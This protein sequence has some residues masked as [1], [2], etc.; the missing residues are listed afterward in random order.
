MPTPKEYCPSNSECALDRVTA[1][2]SLVDL[3]ERLLWLYARYFAAVVASGVVLGGRKRGKQTD[4]Y[5][6]PSI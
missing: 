4:P 6:R 2:V 3:S 1:Q 5:Q